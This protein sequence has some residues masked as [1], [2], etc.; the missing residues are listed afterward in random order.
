MRQRVQNHGV[1]PQK[2]VCIGVWSDHD[3]V[4]PIERAANPYRK[5]WSLGDRLVVMYAGNFGLVH[6]VETMCAAAEALN[7][8]SRIR[9]AFVGGG[10]R[11]SEVEQFV[12]DHDIN[13][14]IAPYQ[15]REK[16]DSM[17]SCGDVHLVTLKPGYEGIVVPSKLFGIMAAGRPAIFIGPPES[18]GALVLTEQDCGIVIPPGDADG[19][20]NTIR[21]LADDPQRCSAMGENARNALQQHYD[22]MHAC[23][24]WQQLLEQLTAPTLG[25]RD[26]S[27]TSIAKPREGNSN[28]SA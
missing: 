25:K 2:T 26:S 10:K 3:E 14:T 7:D 1:N 16:L 19:L 4:Q 28:V 15:P 11:K 27:E 5:E 24:A 22:R 8:D 21:Q 18:E 6:D 9:F 13:A 12:R 20:V 23:A 17:L